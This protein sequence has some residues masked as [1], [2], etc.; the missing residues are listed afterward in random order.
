[1]KKQSFIAKVMTVVMLV[2]VLFTLAS[3]FGGSLELESF[4]VD[5]SSIKTTYNVGDEVDFSGIKAI[6]KYTDEKLNMTYT[7]ENGL[8][9]DYPADI[10][11]TAG[12]K[13]LKVTFEDPNFDNKVQETKVD[14]TVIDPNSAKVD[15]TVVGY[16]SPA[17][18]TAFN[19]KNKNG[20]LEYG[21]AGFSGEFK[22]GGFSYI[23]GDDNEFK[24]LPDIS[25][26][27]EDGLVETL[28]MFYA[29]IEMSILDGESYVALTKQDSNTNTLKFYKD[30]VLIAD[31]DSLNNTYD[32]T[33]DAVG[34][35]IKISV[36]P[37]ADYYEFD[38]DTH[39]V[40]LEFSVVDAYNVYEAWQLAVI[41][42]DTTRSE[43]DKWNTF[44]T[45]KG[46]ADVTTAG[47]VLHNDIKLT[48]NDVPSSPN[49]TFFYTTESE[50]IY[51]NRDNVN[52]KKIIPAGTKYLKDY[53]NVYQ[54]VGTEAFTINGNFFTLDVSAFPLVA[55]P[56][57]FGADAPADDMQYG[58]DF[59][60]ATLIRFESYDSAAAPADGVEK[61]SI[62]NLSIIGNSSRDKYVDSK[63]EL[64]S[65][66]GL[67]FVKSTWH[68]D[69]TVNNVIGNSFFI[70]YFSDN[71]G[72]LVVNDTK[73]YDSYQNAAMVW[74]D[75]YLE[76]NNS[77]LNGCG[78]PAIIAQ[79][80]IDDSSAPNGKNPIVKTNNT[81]MDTPLTGQELWFAAVGAGIVVDSV[82]A[83]S[84][85]LAA[86][87]LGSMVD[88]DGKMNVLGL[89]MSNGDN[90]TAIITK[91]AAQGTLDFGGAGIERWRE[92]GYIWNDIIQHPKFAAGAPFLSVVDASGN[93]HVLYVVQNGDS[94]V[95]YD[96]DNNV[97]NPDPRN[98]GSMEH[99]AICQAFLAAEYITLSQGGLSVVFEF[100]HAN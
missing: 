61:S 80:Y 64:A 26:L 100:Y 10:T 23:V 18:L 77:Y 53:T 66:G 56:G 72:T 68:A 3:C 96:I 41:D 90:A 95:L 50:V 70:T 6:A 40:T 45:D 39:A 27:N 43:Y 92:T 79:S 60:N 19:S 89:L 44:K 17:T 86:G 59:S 62:N 88:A 46:I 52:D 71:K 81:V 69:L 29:N 94:G 36:L 87:G 38:S 97:F 54:R 2:G 98:G 76:F 65:A 75:A 37:S 93:T 4:T 5:K 25:V 24:F 51:T 85:G 55:S 22:N 73:C 8:K 9:L 31:V 28:T 35:K 20:T 63:D 13:E 82:K 49:S 47:I 11:A 67:I 74:A 12:T 84:T 83:L 1:M 30:D 78:G 91:P 21:T 7:L 48:A 33:D 32:F 58:T 42:N 16:Q 99:Y 15:V 14:I 57:V 34:A